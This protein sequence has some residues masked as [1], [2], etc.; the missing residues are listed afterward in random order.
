MDIYVVSSVMHADFS[1]A[2][3]DFAAEN[4]ASAAHS[5]KN[6]FYRESCVAAHSKENT[7]YRDREHI[8]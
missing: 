7:F 6:T 2:A 3:A 8:L 1:G 5:K 4:F